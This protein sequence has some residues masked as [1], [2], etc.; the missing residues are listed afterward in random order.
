LAKSGCVNSIVTPIAKVIP[1]QAPSS[2]I[3][4]KVYPNPSAG[5]F[6]MQVNSNDLE[7]ISIRVMDPL[8]RIVNTMSTNSNETLNFGSDLKSGLYMIE[9][10]QGGK[11]KTTRVVKL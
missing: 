1:V 11:Y 7:K 6:N 4:V 5:N 8:G 3:S 2:D 10:R 9:V